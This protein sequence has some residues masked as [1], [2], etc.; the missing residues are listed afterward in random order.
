MQGSWHIIVERAG[1]T[2]P[3]LVGIGDQGDA[4][5]AAIRAVGGGVVLTSGALAVAHAA[6]LGVQDG[7]V[8][9][10]RWEG[11]S[12]RRRKTSS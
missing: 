5:S 2:Y 12:V 7:Q 1:V 3:V 6:K 11:G 8:V 9:I 4:E 10:A